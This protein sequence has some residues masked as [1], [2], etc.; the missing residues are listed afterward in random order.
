MINNSF[1]KNPHRRTRFP[2]FER[3]LY[4]MR[5][6]WRHFRIGRLPTRLLGNQYRR[7]RELIEIDITYACNL[8]CYNCNR[9]IRQAPERMHMPL[10]MVSDFVDTSISR[11]KQWKRIRVLG[12]AK[13]YA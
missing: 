8:G 9:S 13:L 2:K 5:A 1:G 4:A 11:N 3:W 12:G 7:S 10:T 6:K